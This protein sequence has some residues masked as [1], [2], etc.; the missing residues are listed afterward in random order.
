M[1]ELSDDDIR[2]FTIGAGIL[3]TGGGGDPTK[4]A[5]LLLDDR[6]SGRRLRL[7]GIEEL[8][9]GSGVVVVPYLVGS[10][11]Q[12]RSQQDQV[13]DLI[14]IAVRTYES[15]F[16]VRVLGTVPT[17]VGGLNSAI[18]LHA[19]AYIDIPMVDAD[20]VGRAAPET[21]HTVLNIVGLPL[22]PAVVAAGPEN[23][24]LL[25]NDMS[26]VEYESSIRNLSAK[27][28]GYV[29]VVDS[30]CRPSAV[31]DILIRGTM[32]KALAL[33][34][35]RRETVQKGQD[36]IP[37]IERELG[38]RLLFRGIVSDLSTRNEGGFLR[39][40]VIL[41]GTREW[42]GR[43]F[44]SL[45][46]NEHIMAWSDGRPVVMPPDCLAFLTDEGLP[47]M[48]NAL[49]I[50]AQVNVLAWKSPALWRS[51]KGLE[52]FGPRHFGLDYDYVP[53]ENLAAK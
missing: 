46:I 53:V 39:G 33:G 19:A 4:G 18:A 38:G 14:K 9:D 50:G 6:K 22:I 43:E 35:M 3:G 36:P 20:M 13:S 52:L 34:R 30:A 8:G 12:S 48:N 24:I 32:S 41:S 37:V 27:A 5:E 47:V 29:A 2:D 26:P 40:K 23:V 31:Q 16:N 17:E 42:G 49:E 1:I 45:I 44:S 25:K 10:I 21:C 7:A 15:E 28:N 11:A 51:E